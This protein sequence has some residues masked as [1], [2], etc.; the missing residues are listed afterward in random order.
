MNSQA[1]AMTYEPGLPCATPASVWD[2]N[3]PLLEYC[4]NSNEN[5]TE[6][7]DSGAVPCL[8]AEESRIASGLK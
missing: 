3:L 6:R 1:E 8:G 7:G 5:V 4:V 2:G